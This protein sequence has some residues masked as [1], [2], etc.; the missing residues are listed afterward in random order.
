MDILKIKTILK[1]KVLNNNAMVVL[2]V[3]AH[4]LVMLFFKIGE[5]RCGSFFQLCFVTDCVFL[6]P[7]NHQHDQNFAEKPVVHDFCHLIDRLYTL[8]ASKGLLV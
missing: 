3:N 5:W 1:E 2:L 6:K 8:L 4:I 7:L